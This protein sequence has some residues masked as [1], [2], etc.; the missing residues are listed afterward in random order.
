MP[1]DLGIKKEKKLAKH[2]LSVKRPY[3]KGINNK[4]SNG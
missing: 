1:N 2:C 3:Y 4:H